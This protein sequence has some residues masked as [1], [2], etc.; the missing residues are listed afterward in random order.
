[1]SDAPSYDAASDTHFAD[2]TI[3]AADA[4]QDFHFW[5]RTLN[6]LQR[7][8]STLDANCAVKET[9]MLIKTEMEIV[10]RRRQIVSRM[11][12]KRELMNNKLNVSNKSN[13]KNNNKRMQIQHVF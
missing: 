3:G 6:F 7:E 8:V 10:Y 2:D 5:T 9:N 1:M 11:L 12:V 13:K 4:S